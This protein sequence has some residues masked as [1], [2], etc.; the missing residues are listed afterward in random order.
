[1]IPQAFLLDLDGVIT[2]TARFHYRA[3]KRLCDE[4]GFRFD[5]RD[6]E[7]LKGVSRLR[8]LEII[9]EI[10][11]CSARYS[12]Q[13]KED[14]AAR[15]NV[16]Y[17]EMIRTMTA[18]DILPGV[19]TFLQQCRENRLKLAVA[20]ASRNA[21]EILQLLG[22]DRFFDYVADAARVPRAKPFPDVFLSCSEA[23]GVPPARCVG[24]EDAQAGIEAIRAA[25]MLS[26]GIGLPPGPSAPDIRLDS[27]AQLDLEQL[28]RKLQVKEPSV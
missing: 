5:E 22:L 6:N 10:N 1:M 12:E 16:W 13:K 21:P 9:L 17:G 11:N 23:L 3:W 26:I 20:S 24:V 19:L 7:R 14:M 4:Q 8:S 25:G 28:L 2:D 18:A 27:T 15:K